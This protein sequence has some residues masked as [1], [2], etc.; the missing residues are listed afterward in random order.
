[1]FFAY[2]VDKAGG[3]QRGWWGEGR[4]AGSPRYRGL[5]I[6]TAFANAVP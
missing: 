4:G 2:H 3:A 1:M 6:G 5:A